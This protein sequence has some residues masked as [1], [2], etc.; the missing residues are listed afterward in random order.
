MTASDAEPTAEPP[1]RRRAGTA[2]VDV[3]S[4]I[5]QLKAILGDAAGLREGL[6]QAHKG[7]PNQALFSAGMVEGRAM[8]LLDTYVN[9]QS[10]MALRD[11][12]DVR[13]GEEV[14]GLELLRV[15]F[16]IG[17]KWLDD[18]AAEAAADAE[19][20]AEAEAEA[21]DGAGS[22]VLIPSPVMRG[23]MPPSPSE[24]E[25][26]CARAWMRV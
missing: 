25:R 10:A 18:A 12:R 9:R 15:P 8:M 5:S 2:L 13:A 7:G 17:W 19:A 23:W 14:V 4:T 26:R 11:G 3:R 21:A 16:R 22:R 20:E 1:L 6:F 24:D